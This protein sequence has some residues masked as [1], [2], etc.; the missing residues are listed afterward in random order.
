[1]TQTMVDTAEPLLHCDEVIALAAERAA[2]AD[3]SG[4]LPLEIVDALV[5][6]GVPRHFVPARYGGNDGTFGELTRAMTDLGQSCASA[7]WCGSMFAYTGRLATH[8]PGK[9]Q[10]EIWGGG[11]D[12]LW[13]SGLVPAGEAEA[14]D[15]G[16]RV[17]GRW[18]YVSGAEFADWALLAGPRPGPGAPAPMFLAVPKG[19][20][21]VDRT[22]DA[23]GMRATGT[24]T[25]VLDRVEVPAHRTVPLAEVV[26]GQN[27]AS[28]RVQHNV[29]LMAVG[30]LTCA[31]PALGAARSALDACVAA[32]AG[33]R[34][35]APGGTL[36]LDVALTHAAAEV[37]IAAL[38]LERVTAVLDSG[39]CRPHAARNARDSAYVG[40]LLVSAV[41]ELMKAAGTAAQ[42]QAGAL[43]R[44]WRDVSVAAS[45]AALRFDK[46]APLYADSLTKS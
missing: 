26:A 9:A 29:P 35:G 31:A 12:A 1:M 24:H 3:R 42:D 23:V 36:L 38:L 7:S 30:G 20:F 18:S 40:K 41:N 16:Y 5:T 15:G 32:V 37:D 14:I 21:T 4:Q 2:A 33:K 46:L 45:H 10:D 6:S 13:A 25:V 39:R 34:R 44:N 11:P 8:L 28:D 22:W 17:S 43:Q 27:T 19:E